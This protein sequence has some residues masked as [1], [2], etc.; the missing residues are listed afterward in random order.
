MHRSGRAA[1]ASLSRLFRNLLMEAHVPGEVTRLLQRL[2]A[3]DRDVVATLIPLVYNELHALAEQH[4]RHER[5]GHTLQPTAL[6]HEAF[7]RLV[8]REQACWENR[9]HFL[10]AASAVM[11]SILVNY[12]RDR[13][14]LKR[15]GG[16]RQIQLDEAMAVFED[17]ALDLVALDEALVKLESIDRRQTSI[18]ELRFFG[19]LTAQSTA[20]VLGVSQRT[21]E[22]DWSLAR[23][24]LLRELSEE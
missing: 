17:R 15:G 23:A 21:V 20:E 18:I 10:H 6:V 5:P 9:R 16:A 19:G 8:E 4:L 7:L 24:W 13:R 2:D 1:A 3:G 11:R 12:A 14:R 22:A